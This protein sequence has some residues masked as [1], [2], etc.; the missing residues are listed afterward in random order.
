MRDRR[1]AGALLAL[2]AAE[3]GFGSFEEPRALA[4]AAA[5]VQSDLS[6]L[7]ECQPRRGGVCGA[8][9]AAAR[10]QGV[11][12]FVYHSVLHPQI[13]AMP[14]HWEKM[15][16]EEMLFASGLA[17]TMLQPAAY[18]QNILG[19]WRGILATACSAF[20]IRSRL[21]SFLDLADL[22]TPPRCD[23]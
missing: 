21:R 18:M 7:P 4:R 14:H 12:R 3:V 6:H 17:L 13:E 22:A 5:G 9:A 8:V 20:P 1:H 2:G 11:T 19:G 23:S 15:R 10:T 16:V